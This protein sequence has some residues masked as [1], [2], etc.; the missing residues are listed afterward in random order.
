MASS[1]HNPI[2]LQNQLSYNYCPFS[3]ALLGATAS[4]PGAETAPSQAS[5]KSTGKK[6]NNGKKTSL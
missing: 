1:E 2:L 4:L 6:F 3:A 5:G